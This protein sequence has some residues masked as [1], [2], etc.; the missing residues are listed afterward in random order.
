MLCHVQLVT[1]CL[2]RIQDQNAVVL[3]NTY[4]YVK[5]LLML[6]QLL[7]LTRVSYRGGEGGDILPLAQSHPSPIYIRISLQ[8]QLGTSG[9]MLI[10]S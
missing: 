5:D 4:M 9:Q 7:P 1:E 3:F 2:V 6:W 10:S 8:Q